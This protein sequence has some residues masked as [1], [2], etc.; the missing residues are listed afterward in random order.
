MLLALAPPAFAQASR[1]DLDARRTPQYSRCMNA[2]DV[3]DAGMRECA[4]QE[5]QRQDRALNTR[6]Q[7]VLRGLNARQQGKLRAAQRTWVAYRDARCASMA[8]EDWGTI[9]LLTANEC[10]VDMTLERL[11]DLE[12][13]PPE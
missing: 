13:Y 12:G 1:Q 4:T 2:A 3:T 8:D 9:S 10:M 5:Y 11:I 6:Y 7:T